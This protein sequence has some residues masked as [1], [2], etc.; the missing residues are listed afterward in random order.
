M[1]WIYWF[2]DSTLL[3]I[4]VTVVLIVTAILFNVFGLSRALKVGA[5]LAGILSVVLSFRSQRKVGWNARIQKENDDV[6]RT[7]SKIRKARDDFDRNWNDSGVHDDDGF[8][9]DEPK[10]K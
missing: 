3:F 6:A 1:N 2:S 9:R 10:S 7:N 4:A 5:V 8:R